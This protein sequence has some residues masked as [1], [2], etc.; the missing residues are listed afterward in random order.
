MSDYITEQGDGEMSSLVLTG[1]IKGWVHAGAE[2]V[3]LIE[4]YD[5]KMWGDASA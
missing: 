5:E 1:G 4:E 3:Q 2:Y